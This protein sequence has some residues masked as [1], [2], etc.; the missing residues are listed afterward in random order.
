MSDNFI[1][2]A[3]EVHGD[4]YDYSKVQYVNNHTKIC[5]ICPEHGEFWQSPKN[6]LKGCGC[7]KCSGV[8][9][10]TTEEF[11]EKARKIHNNKY[12][13][14]MVEYKDSNTKICI[15]CPEHGEFW[16][17]P[18]NHLRGEGC[19]LCRNEK[20]SIDRKMD[21]T[22]FIEKARKIHNNKYDYSKVQYT[23]NHTK[24]CII[25]PEHGEFWQTPLNHSHKQGCPKCYKEK[26][27][28]IKKVKIEKQKN[29]LTTEEFIEK[30]RK[31]HNNKYDYSMVEYKDNNTKVCIICPEH[32]EFWQLPEKHLYGQGCKICGYEKSKLK[33]TLTTEEFIKRAKEVHGDKYDYSMV[34]YENSRIKVC[35]IC[36]EHGEFWQA[37]NS[38]ISGCGC[39]KCA[40]THKIKKQTTTTE[41]FIEKC[42]RKYVNLYDYSEV[43]YINN[44]TQVKII[45]HEKNKKGE[46]H[47][48]F[49]VSPNKFLGR[50]CSCPS[51]SCF[52]SY[53]E[54]EIYNFIC[55]IIGKENV[56]HNDRK[57]LNG[58]ELDIYIPSKK[59][60]CEFNGLFWHSDYISHIN[61]KSHYNKTIEC[62]KKGIKLI[63]IFSDE[64]FKNKKIVLEKIKHTLKS[65]CDYPKIMAR[66]CEVKEINTIDSSDF[67]NTYH[68]QGTSNATVR[69]GAFYDNEL[70]AVMSF[71]ENK[72]GTNHWELIRFASNYNYICQGVG[73]KLFNY[74][75]K[76]YNPDNIKSFA[77]RRWTSIIE[78]NI[79][80]KIGFKISKIIPPD[81]RYIDKNNPNK[82]RIHKFNFRKQTLH[83]K[84]NL[85]LSMTEKEMTEKLG[86]HRVYDCGLIKY[87][88][89]KEI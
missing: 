48:I 64:Y 86:Y 33:N 12:D 88:W 45:C 34:K 60:A 23:N 70:I 14:S 16:Q 56:I 54:K 41:E 28:K 71:L 39:P 20:M 65:S 77:D 7:Q 52:T 2:R 36:P 89:K 31:I 17:L 22:S 10:L 57:T 72:R 13:Y 83:K 76:K 84:Y 67:L 53:P 78:E 50:R 19:I 27:V 81:Y 85:P 55:E 66:K 32:G 61:P 47:G 30:A 46:E 82:G 15:I 68:I 40:T 25:C 87:V 1:K 5:I 6:H 69:L 49:Y 21:V 58:Y 8:Y 35:I 24:V 44:R 80:D 26:K 62:E 43:N 3:K 75:V 9:R 73:G 37:P 38:H 4:K 29:T 79:Y 59:I 18:N 42:K 11:I 63:Q 51:C 74:F